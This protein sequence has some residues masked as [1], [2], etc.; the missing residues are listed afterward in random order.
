MPVVALA[1]LVTS[2]GCSELN[3]CV[4]GSDEVIVV[5]GGTTYPDSLVYVSAPTDGPLTPFPAKR[6]V[7]F[8]HGLGVT[9]FFWDSE[10]S[11]A[12]HGT[13]GAG[14]G[15]I[16]KSAGN[17]TLLDCMDSDVIVLRNDTCEDGFFVR[18]VVEAAPEGPTGDHSCTE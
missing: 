14:G 11:F 16:S 2:S 8:T 15:S 1:V 10:L 13:N 12:P 6:P 18:V 3:N 9:P 5:E 4:E 17:P 7:Q